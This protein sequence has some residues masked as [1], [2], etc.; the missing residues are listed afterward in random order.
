MQVT[1]DPQTGHTLLNGEDVESEIRTLEVSR[2]ASVVASY[3]FVRTLLVAQQQRL[4]ETG[5]IVMDG[6]DIGTVV[7]PEAELKIFL[8]ATP[9]V[10]AQRRYD[11]LRGKGDQ[12]TTMEMVSADLKDRDY[13]D[14]HRAINPLRQAEDAVVIDN[15]VLSI[16]EQAAMALALAR[17]REQK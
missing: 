12:T 10:R 7:F 3:D 9:E 5:G 4:G 16:D 17:Q 6:R 11:E 2:P 15:S 13:R 1:F 8:T 14:S